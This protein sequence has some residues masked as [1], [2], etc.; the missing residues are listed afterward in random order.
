MERP[1]SGWR[2]GLRQDGSSVVGQRWSGL[3]T[4]ISSSSTRRSLSV[5]VT[6]F[7][8]HVKWDAPQDPARHSLS[9]FAGSHPRERRRQ[10][11]EVSPFY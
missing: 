11:S 3:I 10:T 4:R 8:G 5:L 6:A 2:G 9:L 7:K 1:W